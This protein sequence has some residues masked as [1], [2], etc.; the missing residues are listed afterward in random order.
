MIRQVAEPD[1]LFAAS[2]V[3]GLYGRKIRAL[4]KAY[5]GSYDF[6]RFYELDDGCAAVFNSGMTL[7]AGENADLRELVDFIRLNEIQSAE[8]PPALG[9][10][11]MPDGY[12]RIERVLFDFMPGEFPQAMQVDE[13]P[14]LDAV[15]SVLRTGFSLENAYGLWLT[16]T[17][18][19][20]RH[21]VSQVFL[22]ENTTATLLH[23]MDGFA[24][25]GQVATLPEG[26]G[27]GQARTLLYWLENRFSRQGIRAQLF[28]REERVSFYRGIGFREAGRDF[29]FERKLGE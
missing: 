8:M 25:V 13:N 7:C 9:E 21:G 3:D 28:A 18:H 23:S 6:C 20:I 27:K 22:Y 17:S 26:R 15:F 1:R 29:I 10:K 16:D 19:R 11:L 5:G 14:P 12:S 24:F 4:A 2:P